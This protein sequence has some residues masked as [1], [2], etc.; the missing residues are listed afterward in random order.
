M[1]YF[2]KNMK[3]HKY[4]VPNSCNVTYTGEKLH[5]SPV[6]GYEKCDRCWP[7]LPR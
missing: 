2:V 3:N 6:Q 1:R 5:D 7:E 4:P